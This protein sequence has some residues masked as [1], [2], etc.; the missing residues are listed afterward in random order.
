MCG[1]MSGVVILFKDPSTAKF[2]RS[3]QNPDLTLI[4]NCCRDFLKMRNEKLAMT[5]LTPLR[6]LCVYVNELCNVIH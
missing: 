3:A 5:L 1:C 4:K 2:Q 6:A